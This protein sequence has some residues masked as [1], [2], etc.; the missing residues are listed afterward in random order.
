MKL[1]RL[2]LPAALT[3]ASLAAIAWLTL[4]SAPEQTFESARTPLDCLVCGDAGLAD[5]LLNVLLFLPLGAGLAGLGR[6]LRFTAAAAFLTSVTVELLQLTVV[7]GRDASLSDVL[8]NTGGGILGWTLIGYGVALL[9][10]PPRRA[11]WLALGSAALWAAAFAVSAWALHPDPA[12][13]AYWGQW[14]H[15]FPGRGTFAGRVRTA[16]LDG[17]PVPDGRLR[18][19]D[20]IRSGLAS[21]TFELTVEAKS[22]REWEDNAQIFGIANDRGEIFLEWRQKGRDYEFTMRTRAARLRLHSVDLL[23][24]D[25]APAAPGQLVSLRARWDAGTLTLAGGA[26][27]HTVSRG[28]VLA[29]AG[30]WRFVWPWGRNRGEYAELE[31]AIWVAMGLVV[32]GYWVGAGLRPRDARDG[33]DGTPGPVERWLAAGTAASIVFVL[34]VLP[35][36]FGLQRTSAADWGAAAL[37]LGSGALLAYM[38]RARRASGP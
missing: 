38:P 18:N 10:P 11:A 22:G 16:T 36:A 2:A 12:T 30:S 23:L 37:G 31:N 13:G 9:Y 24:P 27:G 14:A 4:K 6:S 21:G 7:T 26:A 33:P 15:D 5:V 32:V 34:L 35:G 19:T 8:T 20:E 25:A 28:L 3:A 17:A 29:P 1:Q